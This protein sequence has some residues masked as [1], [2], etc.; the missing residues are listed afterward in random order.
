M[1]TPTHE[2]PAL[3]GEP[4]LGDLDSDNTLL[5]T[6][7]EHEGVN[8][9]IPSHSPLGDASQ[10][11]LEATGTKEE[12]KVEIHS[13]SIDEERN[14]QC[15]TQLVTGLPDSQESELYSGEDEKD[16]DD[17]ENDEDTEP[18]STHDG[19]SETS[20]VDPACQTGCQMRPYYII[21]TGEL[22]KDSFKRPSHVSLSLG[23]GRV[24]PSDY[25][26]FECPQAKCQFIFP[27]ASDR[28]E[29]VAAVHK[30]P[31]RVPCHVCDKTF[32]RKYELQIHVKTIHL[33]IKDNVCPE[34]GCDYRTAEKGKGRI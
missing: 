10:L 12:V 31:V 22:E 5:S 33:N 3:L 14:S 25:E 2:G 4:S 8:A 13:S 19:P 26:E 18:E 7:F 6:E 24:P 30:P 9:E 21:H 20:K 16:D 11:H 1:A 15:Q 29:H 32:A 17:L 23:Q 28:D 34:I 27:T